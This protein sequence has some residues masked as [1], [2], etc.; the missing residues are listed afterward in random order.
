MA[1]EEDKLLIDLKKAVDKVFDDNGIDR[2]YYDVYLRVRELSAD[3]K[4]VLYTH[5]LIDDEANKICE[6]CHVP[7]F[8]YSSKVEGFVCADCFSKFEFREDMVKQLEV[9][10][11]KEKAWLETYARMKRQ[12]LA[13]ETKRV[14]KEVSD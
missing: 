4:S 1:D 10:V 2:A 7:A 5:V 6:F 13:Q 8:H 9:Y 12:S 3:F 11:E 14:L